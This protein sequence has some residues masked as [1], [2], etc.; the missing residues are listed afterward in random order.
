MPLLQTAFV[1]LFYFYES[2][3]RRSYDICFNCGICEDC[4]AREEEN[5]GYMLLG[6]LSSA[7]H[8]ELIA[9]IVKVH[10]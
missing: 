5:D 3:C 7:T 1:R 2:E 6:G 9:P 4:S 10:A 8:L